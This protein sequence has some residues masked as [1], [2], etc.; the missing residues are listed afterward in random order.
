M[1][2]D[3]AYLHS[4]LNCWCEEYDWRR[5]EETLNRFPQ[6]TCELDGMT[7]HFFHI[8]SERKDAPT[9]LLIHGWPDSFLRYAKLFPLLT[10][11]N[12]VVPLPGFAFS[13]LPQKGYA[14]IYT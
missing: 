10:D 11:F 4:L 14:S 7:I 6:F 13:P 2:T 9:L 1:G 8:C 5:K 3:S 12:L